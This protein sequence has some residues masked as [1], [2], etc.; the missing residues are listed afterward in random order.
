MRA[1]CYKGWGDK[2]EAVVLSRFARSLVLAACS[3]VGLVASAGAQTVAGQLVASGLSRPTFVTA[4]RGDTSRIFIVEDK[5]RAVN[6]DPYT[7]RIRILNIPA[8]TLNATPFLS[9]SGVAATT[10][11][12]YI[13][14]QGLLGV[15]FHPDFL[16]NGYFYV[17]HTRGSDYHVLI[18][19]YRANP[20]YATSTTADPASETLLLD[21]AHPQTNH[22][23]GWIA[24][25]PDGYLYFAVGDGGNGN[26]T[27]PGHVTGGNAQSLGQVLGKLLRIDVNGPD[28]IPGT[29]DDADPVLGTPYRI[30]ATNPFQGAGQRPEIFAYGLR[31]PWRDSFDRLT[32]DLWIGDVGQDTREEIDVGIGN[33]AGRNYGWKCE[34][35]FFCTGLPDCPTCPNIVPGTTQPILDYANSPN[36]AFPP[37][38]FAGIA[39]QGGYVYRGCAMPWLNGTYFFSDYSSPAHI[40]TLQYSAGVVSN[41]VDRSAQLQVSGQSTL[42]QIV[43]FGEDASGELYYVDQTGGGQTSGRVFKMI[44]G[45]ATP[46]CHHVCGTA[47]FNC[48]GAVGTD[49]DIESFFACLSGNCPAPPCW[50]SADFNGDGATGTDTDIEAFF[51]VLGGGAC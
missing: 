31:N 1:S 7:G 19:R 11:G 48:D 45:S 49:A 4:P 2:G 6:T 32:G 23:G 21:I 8:N 28:G 26:D 42:S 35:G 17:H 44:V 34:E 46:D 30:P 12:T 43:S 25:G 22:N 18:E 27:G 24:F 51:R 50:N 47:D 38:N 5:W 40:F 3:V 13:D 41:I 10:S 16:N 9:I 36:T 20:P 37:L 33:P 15:A 14:E 39:V 29:A